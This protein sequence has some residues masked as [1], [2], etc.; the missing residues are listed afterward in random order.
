MYRQAL[1]L[2]KGG[3]TPTIVP[4]WQGKYAETETLQR[5]TREL[6]QGRLGNDQPSML[7]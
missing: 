3:E 4:E 6:K 7:E 1:E 2:K 5:Q